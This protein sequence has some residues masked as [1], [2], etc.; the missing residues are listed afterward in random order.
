MESDRLVDNQK[1]YNYLDE[2]VEINGYL[3]STKN[4]SYSCLSLNHELSDTVIKTEVPQGRHLG[5]FSTMVLFVSRMVG[6]GIFAT[7]SS[8]F[9]SSGGNI[10]IFA[11]IWIVATLLAYSGLYI[12][13]EFGSWLPKSGGRKNFLE[14][15]YDKPALMMNV[16]FACYSVLTGIA[17]SN[18]IIFAKYLLVILGYTNLDYSKFVSIAIILVIIA[19]HGFSVKF[20]I[21]IQN[22]LGTLKFLLIF[23]M[24]LTGFYTIFFYKSDN[25]NFTHWTSY[26]GNTG[27]SYSS[28][29]SAFIGAFYCFSGWDSV[30]VVSSEIKNPNRTLK[31]AG[32][33]SIFIC[34]VCYAMMNFAYLKV[35][36]FEEIK[37]AGPLIGSVLFKKLFGKNL[38][39][40]LMSLSIVLSTASNI[41]VVLYGL[42]RMNQEVFREGYVPF[43]NILSRNWPND[44]PLPSLMICGTLTILWLLIL[45]PEGG[46]FEYLVNMEGYGN[47]FF[48]FLTAVGLFI[49]RHKRKYEIPKIRC[50]SLGAISMVLVSIYLLVAPFF[51]NQELNRVGNFPS[52]QI[53]ALS[54]IISC[55]S[56]WFLVFYAIPKVLGYKLVPV[57]EK[58]SDGMIITSWIRSYES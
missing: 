19:I 29:A 24:C 18:S 16:S 47:Q 27:I 23:L 35:L 6:S 40:R 48:L 8:I 22:F 54:I 32:P 38:G 51:G 10:L 37:E 2:D 14:Q 43:S 26:Q 9:V 17:I 44:A 5:V 36:T 7:P 3:V 58:L 53:T 39:S 25:I 31:L 50:S 49:Y 28:L 1:T 45:P 30:H 34:F 52:F 21:K 56:Y 12:F 41:F 15:A 13:L 55:T 57:S 42:S 33:L 11:L 46:S 20:G 4:G